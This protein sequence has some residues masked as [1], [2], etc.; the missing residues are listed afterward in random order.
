ETVVQVLKEGEDK[1]DEKAK[2]EERKVKLGDT[3]YKDVVV[4]EGLK[5]GDLIKV[6]G[7]EAAIAF[8]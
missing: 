5:E 1:D 7:F 4:I 2:T 3:D 8:D 6:R